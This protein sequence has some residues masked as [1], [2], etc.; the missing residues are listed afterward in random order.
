[1]VRQA[2]SKVVVRVLERKYFEDCDARLKVSST[3]CRANPDLFG[4]S[5]RCF[6]RQMQPPRLAA[7]RFSHTSPSRLR[8]V[9]K[10]VASGVHDQRSS[11]N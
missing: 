10:Q 4:C 1:M 8:S 9:P 7:T 5:K 3:S 11:E 6:T 2:P